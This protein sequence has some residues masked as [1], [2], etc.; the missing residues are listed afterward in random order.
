M[1]K[2]NLDAL[3]PREDFAVKSEQTVPN[4]TDKFR[5]GDLIK[6]DSFVYPVLRKPDFQRETTDWDKEKIAEFIKSFLNG[7]LIPAV[8]LWQSGQYI[9]VID[10]AHR[11]S[12]L[13][14]WAN[15]D[16]GDGYISQT[17]FNSE[18]DIEQKKQADATRKYINK[19]IGSYRDYKEIANNPSLPTQDEKK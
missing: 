10:G 13:I 16:Y 11:L 14:S 8:I 5:I 1:G 17:F 3:I 19:E 4:M 15:D 9:F 7:E 18:I 12:A 6:G 2:V